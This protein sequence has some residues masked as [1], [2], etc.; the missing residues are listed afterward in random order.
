MMGFMAGVLVKTS[1]GYRKIEDIEVGDM[2]LT[3]KRRYKRVYAKDVSRAEEMVEVSFIDDACWYVVCCDGGQR[4]LIFDRKGEE[5]W[6]EAVE[7][8]ERDMVVGVMGKRNIY[9]DL[10]YVIDAMDGKVYRLF[11][12]DDESFTV[13]EHNV[14]VRNLI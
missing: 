6:R 7:L 11:V 8:D 9:Y 10:H 12:E 4:F 13:T 2:V 1:E 3:H 14:A 5:V